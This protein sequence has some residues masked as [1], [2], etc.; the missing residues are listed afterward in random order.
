MATA[1]I[2]LAMAG[3]A[4]VVAA[5]RDRSDVGWGI[6]ER[7]WLRLLLFNAILPFS[8][9]LVGVFIL[10]IDPSRRAWRWSSGFAAICLI[11]YAVMIV[12]SLRP[13]TA[14]MLKAAGGGLDWQPCPIWRP[15]RDLPPAD[16]ECCVRGGVLAILRRHPRPH[17]RSGLPVRPTCIDLTSA[18]RK[19]RIEKHL[20]GRIGWN[21]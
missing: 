20:G 17:P 12:K 9:S 7:F 16:M 13:I 2:S 10:V 14:D 18:S 15:H 19:R 4:G 5:Y 3:F 1:Q 8:F 6:V 11:P 21:T